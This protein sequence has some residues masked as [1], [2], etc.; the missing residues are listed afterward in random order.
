MQPLLANIP[1]FFQSISLIGIGVAFV[2]ALVGIWAWQ[3]LAVARVES[4]MKEE[5][6]RRGMSVDEI[7][8][9]CQAGKPTEPA[10]PKPEAA[11]LLAGLLVEVQCDPQEIERTLALVRSALP[12]DQQNLAL[13]LVRLEE[14]KQNEDVEVNLEQ[15]LAVVRGLCGASTDREAPSQDRGRYRVASEGPGH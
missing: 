1:P 13:A 4:A 8:R 9:V 7:E 11:A 6:L 2:L 5:L 15:V 3:Q 14:K 10:E 12:Q